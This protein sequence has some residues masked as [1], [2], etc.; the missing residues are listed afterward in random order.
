MQIIALSKNNSNEQRQQRQ[1]Q[2]QTTKS[3]TKS[4]RTA[5]ARARVRACVRAC[6]RNRSKQ[7]HASK[8]KRANKQ[9]LSYSNKQTTCF[10]SP[11]CG[12]QIKR[13]FTDRAVGPTDW[14]TDHQKTKQKTDLERVFTCSTPLGYLL[15]ARYS[16]L[17]QGI[18]VSGVQITVLVALFPMYVRTFS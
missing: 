12:F 9:L 1:Q 11:P 14:F 16:P 2:K 8:V 4:Q 13:R 6:V 7:Q 18:Y 5:L 17:H 15:Y 3:N 10:C